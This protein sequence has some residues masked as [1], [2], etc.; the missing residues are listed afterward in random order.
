MEAERRGIE[1][2][3]GK[4]IVD[5]DSGP[6]GVQAHFAD[7]STIEADLLVGADGLK[8]RVRELI[9][10]AAPRARYIPLLNTGGYAQGISVDAT[11]GAMNM[12]MGRKAFFAYYRAPGDEVWWFA[13]PPM[14][15]EPA[16]GV[17][18]AIP[19]AEWRAQLIELFAGDRTDA[20]DIINATPGELA[21]WPTYD[22][23]TVPNWHRDRMMIIGDAAHAVSPASGQGASMAIEDSVV[24]AKSLRDVSDL[25]AA[26]RTY[27]S[28]RRERVERVV[29]Q[30][31]RNG[32]QKVTTPFKRVVRDIVL[33]QMMARP[34][35]AMVDQLRW[36]WDHRLDW[37][38][39]VAPVA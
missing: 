13:N 2:R 9:D 18:E 28:A 19:Q 17:V 21:K 23:P 7:G 37:E 39:P 11:P 8:S 25:G 3:Y 1:V 12:V 22:Y 34:N 5:A 6:H 15:R 26:L 31:K 30:G 38:S 36:M 4:R 32:D 29:A 33:K 14:R 16:P 20:V 35:N 24:L 10:P 27:E